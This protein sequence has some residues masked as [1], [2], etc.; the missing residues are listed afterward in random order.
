MLD[1][2]RFILGNFGIYVFGFSREIG[3]VDGL[4]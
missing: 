4:C 3:K 2:L 1:M